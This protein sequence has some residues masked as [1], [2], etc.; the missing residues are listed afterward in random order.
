MSLRRRRAVLALP[1]LMAFLALAAVPAQAS[2]GGTR[3]EAASAA[4]ARL[5]TFRAP[6]AVTHLAIY[7]R[8]GSG[9]G[10]RAALSFDGRRYRSFRPVAID[11]LSAARRGG[12]TYGSVMV[13]RGVR[14]VRV[15]TRRPLH[16]LSV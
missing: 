16:H 6:G 10:V 8:G 4:V 1:V 13:A 14:A 9:A 3:A 11:D 7:W 2:R 12:E 15:A 5:H